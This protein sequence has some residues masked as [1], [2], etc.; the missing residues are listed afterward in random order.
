ME[1]KGIYNFHLKFRG[2]KMREHVYY[3]QYVVLVISN[4]IF[5]AR[6]PVTVTVTTTDKKYPG[7]RFVRIEY[8]ILIDSAKYFN[9]PK[10]SRPLHA[11][12]LLKPFE[13]HQEMSHPSDIFFLRKER[14][15]PADFKSPK[16]NSLLILGEGKATQHCAFQMY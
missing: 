4:P 8:I 9:Y 14:I 3:Y 10:C 6:H 7:L 15:T 1:N 5:T 16:N 12:I 13:P 11:F 2:K